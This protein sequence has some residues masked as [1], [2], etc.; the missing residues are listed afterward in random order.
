MTYGSIA[1]EIELAEIKIKGS[2][3]RK[4]LTEVER[5]TKRLRDAI[6]VIDEMQKKYGHLVEGSGNGELSGD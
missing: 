6:A 2:D 5:D 3:L 1:L 4:R